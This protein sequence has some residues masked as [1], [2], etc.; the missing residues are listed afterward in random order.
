M[1]LVLSGDS[2]LGRPMSALGHKRTSMHLDLM[3]AL[4]PKADIAQRG[5]AAVLAP[6]TALALRLSG[7]ILLDAR[8]LDAKLCS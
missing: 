7:Q 6:R 8:L 5:D 1:M 2:K 3:S 4:H